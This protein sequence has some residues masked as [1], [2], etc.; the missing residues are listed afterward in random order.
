VGAHRSSL[1]AVIRWPLISNSNFCDQFLQLGLWGVGGSGV[2]S[3]LHPHTQGR[4]S[5]SIGSCALQQVSTNHVHATDK[6][7]IR[8]LRFTKAT[9]CG[10]LD[11]RSV[12]RSLY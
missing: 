12:V 4:A 6:R 11:L 10:Y 7:L 3:L 9:D 8:Q 2:S 1:Q 5:L